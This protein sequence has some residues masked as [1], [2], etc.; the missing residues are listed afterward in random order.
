MLWIRIQLGSVPSGI[1]QFM[2]PDLFS[3]YGSGFRI[4]IRIQSIKIG[5][6]VGLTEKTHRLKKPDF[7]LDQNKLV[8]RV[9]FLCQ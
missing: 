6:K 1:Q 4:W 3:E 2:D 5:K 8:A 7:L 9:S